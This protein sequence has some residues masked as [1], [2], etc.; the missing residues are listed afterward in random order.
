MDPLDALIN[1]FP[2]KSVPSKAARGVSPA[3]KHSGAP[4]VFLLLSIALLTAI[5]FSTSL[6]NLRWFLDDKDPSSF[7]A[8][9]LLMLVVQLVFF[10]KDEVEPAPDVAGYVAAAVLFLLGAAIFLLLPDLMSIRF[11]HL[12]MDM[13]VLTLFFAGSVAAVFG[14]RGAWALRFPLVYL[15]LAWPLVTLPLVSLEP[16]L[17]DATADYVEWVTGLFGLAISR[18][19]GN[20]FASLTSEIPIIIAPACVAL[21]AL[22]GFG[23]FMLPFA[24]L[25]KGDLKRRL[26]WLAAGMALIEA[27]NL[28]RIGI[29]ILVWYYYGLSSAIQVFHGTSGNV[30]FNLSVIVM[31]LAFPRF[32][33]MLPKLRGTELI[34]GGRKGVERA[35]R[36]LR[37]TPAA[38]LLSLALLVLPA[39]GFWTLEQRMGDYLWLRQFEGQE[40]VAVQADV[41][42]MPFPE[43]WEVLGTQIGF[44][45]ELVVTRVVFEDEGGRQWQFMFFSS[46]NQSAL[47]FSAEE[48]LV[49]EGYSIDKAERELLGRSLVAGVVGYH[50]GES[51]Y[52]TV[53]WAQPVVVGGR[54]TYGAFLFTIGDDANFSGRE[55]L[56]RT[57]KEFA[58][59]L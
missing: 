40:F 55:E 4:A 32:G 29:I 46:N 33:L 30:L 9:V 49:Q 1:S 23:A 19:P 56:V 15:L 48:K 45:E 10:Y 22:L 13:L 16:A 27:L 5:V 53:Y 57:A 39:A 44:S 11:W 17:T 54:N 2:N 12:R 34:A 50:K 51:Y 38:A 6:L 37:T 21:A 3:G 41:A 35:I 36:E 47:G 14:G 43:E 28:A 8:V 26:L 20:L 24:Y 59:R 18:E 25:F 58:R 42:S 7:I 31:L 52:S